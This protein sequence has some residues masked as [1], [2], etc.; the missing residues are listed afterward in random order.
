MQKIW[1][2]LGSESQGFQGPE[3]TK[4]FFLGEKR[5]LLGGG[6]L[7]STAAT[8]AMGLG[9]KEKGLLT[10]LGADRPITQHRRPAREECILPGME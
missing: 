1:K 7:A 2:Q 4:G 10:G 5:L 8:G 9:R 3:V 6:E